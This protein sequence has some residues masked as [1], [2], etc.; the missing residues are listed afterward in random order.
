MLTGF[1]TGGVAWFL[2][3]RR[4]GA[5]HAWLWPVAVSMATFAL[6]VWTD[7][8]SAHTTHIGRFVQAAA[9]H[10]QTPLAILA[11][12][13]AIQWGLFTAPPAFAIYAASAVFLW[14]ARGPLAPARRR[15]QRQRPWAAIA[16]PSL[17]IGGGFG[18]LLNDTGIVMW[19]LMAA[20]ALGAAAILAL[21]PAEM[22]IIN[23]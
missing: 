8:H 17:L 21:E 3:A 19:G 13:V 1:V 18:M 15:L 6:V 11:N 9:H 4:C 10:S 20:V 7:V 5:R 22:A 23:Q 16:V 2:V 14:L 12:K